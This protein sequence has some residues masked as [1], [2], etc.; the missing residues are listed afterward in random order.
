[1]NSDGGSLDLEKL[2]RVGQPPGALQGV[3]YATRIAAA[4]AQSAN[5]DPAIARELA[6]LSSDS[7]TAGEA[8][9]VAYWD[10]QHRL[11]GNW[12][13]KTPMKLADIGR[14]IAEVAMHPSAQNLVDCEVARLL[15]AAVEAS[16]SL[17]AEANDPSISSGDNI[18]AAWCPS[19]C[20][21]DVVRAVGPWVWMRDGQ[22]FLDAASGL[23][24][25]PLGHGHPAPIAGF[26]A[27]AVSVASINPFSQTANVLQR[28]STRI[29]GLCRLDG[30]RVF[31]CSSGSEAV[32]T[33]LRL[34]LAA[35]GPGNPVW[36][37][38]GAFHGAT[39]GAA[40]LSSYATLWREYEHLER[41][42][43]HADPSEWRGR[44]LAFIEPIRMGG[45][46]NRVLDPR[47]IDDFRRD[48]G[49]VVADEIASGLGRTYWP[50]ACQSIGVPYDLVV[51]GKGLANGLAP[52]SCVAISKE[53]VQLL[54]E[55]GTDFGHTHSN[56]L[57]SAGAAEATLLQLEKLDHA[58]FVS[59]FRTMLNS[60]SK[61]TSVSFRQEGATGCLILP[62]QISRNSVDLAC[63]HARV[64]C[65]LPT[66]VE[67]IEWLVLAPPLTCDDEALSDMAERL[68]N[69]MNHLDSCQ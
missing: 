13:R 35:M 46:V 33:A 29:L 22:K 37:Q 43:C 11:D 24:N 67:Q 47:V 5:I 60:I 17:V 69:V 38:P 65:H 40:M 25:I 4:I 63:R 36:A 59:R 42:V 28:L 58:D 19:T 14:R 62:R 51:L 21:M 12:K 23:W 2:A 34:G 20:P 64:L 7:I 55:K 8:D 61:S 50:L 26:L 15:A 9:S 49:L 3:S 16:C 1:M 45:G 54:R 44:G 39:M 68:C 48:G 52:L 57:A 27:Q 53:V 10:D 56:H 32:E 66:V 30:G 31:F 41:H 6:A 18:P